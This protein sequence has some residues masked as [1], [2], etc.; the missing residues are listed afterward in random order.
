MLLDV[1]IST[2]LGMFLRSKAAPPVLWHYTT[3]AGAKSILELREVRLGCHAFMNDPAEGALAWPLVSDCWG[4]AIEQAGTHERLELNDLRDLEPAVSYFDFDRPELPPTF[5]FSVTELED[6]LSQ[7]SRYG[8]NGAGI[9]LGFSIKPRALPAPSQRPW[10]TGADLVR[11]VYDDSSNELAPGLRQLLTRLL[12]EAIPELDTSTAAENLLIEI[13]H[14][15]N[16]QIKRASYAEEREW[17]V[18]RRVTRDSTP[19]YE[20][21]ANRFGLAPYLPLALGEG[22]SLTHLTL[23]PKLAPE[24]MWSVKWLCRKYEH[25]LQIAASKLAYR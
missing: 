25:E 4:S 22:M 20:V 19:L 23:G 18:I 1:A 14:Q 13:I 12:K 10:A 11:V 3:V 9:A 16:P 6:S 7:W 21:G 2:E 5:L 8:D 15:L 17:R 24:N